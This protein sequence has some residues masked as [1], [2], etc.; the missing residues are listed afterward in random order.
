MKNK[1]L[2][3]NVEAG[4][5]LENFLVSAVVS[6]LFI[7]T[8]LYLLNYPQLGNGTFHIA[9]VLWGGFLMMGALVMLFAFLNRHIRYVAAVV[10]G[11]GFGTF[12]DELGKFITSDNNYFYQP[13]IALIYVIF[14]LLFLLARLFEKY[15]HLSSVEYAVN[16]LEMTKEAIIYDMDV[17]EKKQAIKFLKQ[18]DQN[19]NVIKF[20]TET[21][22]RL[23]AIPVGEKNI[24]SRTKNRLHELYTFLIRK[25]RFR[26][27]VVAFFSI[28]TLYSLS[29]AVID[30]GFYDTFM[31][32][33][34]L[35]A[36]SLSGI[37]VLLGIYYFRRRK[38]VLSFELFRFSVL[39]SIFLTQFFVFYRQQVS[40]VLGLGFYIVILSVLQYL[41]SEA[42]SHSK[43]KVSL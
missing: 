20:L 43:H 3:R 13:A 33:G 31:E 39:V 25:S 41:I 22:V 8:Y 38:R 27:A 23:E 6:I 1:L 37:F 18:S 14:I 21:I 29:Q 17:D 28:S 34:E 24:I 2:I 30:I 9:H 7:R 32:W 19:D 42:S 10:G 40:A 5:I 12:I 36:S 15:V 26:K 35:F 11:V 4:Y 16:A